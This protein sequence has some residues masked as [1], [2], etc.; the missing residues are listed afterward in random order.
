MKICRFCGGRLKLT[1]NIRKLQCEDC[2]RVFRNYEMTV[3][4]LKVGIRELQGADRLQ[5]L[6]QL[7]AAEWRAVQ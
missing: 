5:A 7:A 1:A 3:E 6:R 4:E 2:G